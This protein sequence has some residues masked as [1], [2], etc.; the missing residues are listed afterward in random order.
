MRVV[1]DDIGIDPRL[2]YG[3]LFGSVR[4]VCLFD[5][6]IPWDITRALCLHGGCLCHP[7]SDRG[8]VLDAI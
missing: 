2:W 6:T 4:R 5:P 1:T 3:G 7:T 8:E